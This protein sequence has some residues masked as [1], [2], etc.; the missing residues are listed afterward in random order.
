M[1]AVNM[2]WWSS[3]SCVDEEPL[4]F[5]RANSGLFKGLLGGILWV[6]VIEGRGIQRKLVTNQTSLPSSVRNQAKEAGDLHG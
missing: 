6:T 2:R 4:D 1:V 5:R 3:G